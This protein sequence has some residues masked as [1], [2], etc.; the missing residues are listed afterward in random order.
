MKKHRLL[1]LIISCLLLTGCT[2]DYNV[3]IKNDNTVNENIMLNGQKVNSNKEFQKIK[4][5][6]KNQISNTLNKYEYQYNIKNENNSVV[7]EINKNSNFEIL[8][9]NSLYNEFF[10][11]YELFVNKGIKTFK[12]TGTNYLAELFVTKNY[13]QDLKVEKEVDV[14]NVNIK[15][16]NIVTE[17]NADKYDEKTNTYTWIFTENDIQ[18]TINFSYD[19]D[20][21]F[22]KE[23]K[24]SF[25]NIGIIIGIILLII[26]IFITSFIFIYRK[27]DEL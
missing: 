18:K 10:E 19:T 11:D 14:L 22:E 20:Q 1:A 8:L 5:E 21:L 26:V 24:F 16:E 7:V 15:F 13:E 2:V 12:N 23:K 3:E 27:K 6:I 25:D 17:H 9:S 4:K